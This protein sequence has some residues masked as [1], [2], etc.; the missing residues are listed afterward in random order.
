VRRWLQTALI[1]LMTI[2]PLSVWSEVQ[3]ESFD[4]TVPQAPIPV[5]T[6]DHVALIYELR[7]TN[8]ASEPL[9]VR[10]LRVINPDNGKAI[11]SFEGS[12]L[13]SRLVLLGGS[14]LGESKLPN[15]AIRPGARAILFVEV[16]LNIGSVPKRLQHELVFA[17]GQEVEGSNP[18][19]PSARN[20]SPFI[21]LRQLLC[22][23]P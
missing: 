7:L 14:I 10:E 22:F 5:L 3:R 18:F 2:V 20:V 13:A 15:T 17:A 1:G 8:F 23:N 12:D 16:G 21:A 19:V 9:L 6:E 4:V 11:A